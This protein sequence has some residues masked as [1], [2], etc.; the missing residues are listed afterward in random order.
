MESLALAV[1][2]VAGTALYGGPIAFLLSL[3]RPDKISRFRRWFILALAT[4]AITSGVYLLYVSI[5]E[6]Y[7]LGNIGWVGLLGLFTGT[8]AIWRLSRARNIDKS[9]WD[10]NG[11][12]EIYG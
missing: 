3:F 7:G 11:E 5:I 9:G 6:G 8:A 4:L 12:D 2:I 10:S 1:L